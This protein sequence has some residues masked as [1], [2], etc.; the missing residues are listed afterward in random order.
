MKQLLCLIFLF[1][2]W[3]SHGF[4]QSNSEPFFSPNGHPYGLRVRPGLSL[5][6]AE[7]VSRYKGA[8][9]LTSA[10]E[11]LLLRVESDPLGMAHYRYQ[12]YHRG[13]PVYGAQLI[14]HE[15]SGRA[16]TLNGKWVRNLSLSAVHPTLS[17][18]EALQRAL[19]SV[20]ARRYLWQSARAEALLKRLRNNPRATFYPQPQ[21]V[22]A[23]GE[24]SD[25]VTTP[26]LCWRIE[27]HV[28]DPVGR[29][30]VLIDAHDG[31]LIDKADLICHQNTPGVAR[32][33]TA[34]NALS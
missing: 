30:E 25:Q 18:A 8:L 19:Q 5:S 28:E 32:R 27:L 34:V 4:S 22:I 20:P 15:H 24:L 3:L 6:A 13:V 2:W 17:A 12:Q 29:Y 9:G 1:P 26:R 7:I 11:W 33:A 10:D 23:M 16:Q 21:L 31:R 14:V